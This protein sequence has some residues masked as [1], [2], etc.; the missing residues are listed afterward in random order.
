M[1]PSEQ[2]VTVPA[3]A[4]KTFD[5]Q[6]VYNLIVHAPTPT[7][8]RV[9][10]ELLPYNAQSGELGPSDLMVTMSTDKL[11]EAI[12]AVP[13]MAAA[14]EAVIAA[15]PPMKAWIATQQEEQPSE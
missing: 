15:V 5:Q 14:F 7:S 2:P 13:E 12:A 11:W 4:E 10:I 1:I 8:G 9:S 6:W 3:V